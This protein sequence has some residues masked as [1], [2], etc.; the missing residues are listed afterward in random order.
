MVMIR[1]IIAWTT[2]FVTYIIGFILGSFLGDLLNFTAIILPSM[3]DR[4]A[5]PLTTMA[6]TSNGL[7]MFVFSKIISSDN[8]SKTSK[9]EL[10]FHITL[11]VFGLVYTISCII[12][13]AFDL[14]WYGILSMILCVITVYSDIN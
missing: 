7:S 10:A 14:L 1:H 4:S 11:G 12:T 6:L 9:S 5:I 3:V 2:G 8:Y 13:G